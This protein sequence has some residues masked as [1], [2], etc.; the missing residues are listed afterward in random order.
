MSV[1]EL[2]HFN[3]VVPR[4]QLA[5]VVAFYVE[6]LALE[7]R[8]FEA[9]GRKLYWLYAGERPLVHLTVVDDDGQ[10]EPGMRAAPIDH[11]AFSAADLAGTCGRL[12]QLGIEHRV[13]PYPQMGFTQVVLHDPVGLKI[14]LN[15]ATA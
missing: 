14:E 1:V 12:G 3:L 9:D 5:A 8:E 4:A 10:C 13:K 15:F 2:N 6:A 11:I 7:Y